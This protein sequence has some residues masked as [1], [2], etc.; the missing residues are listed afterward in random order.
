MKSKLLIALLATIGLSAAAFAAPVTY[1]TDANH[2]FAQFE[3]NHLGFSK[4]TSR[5][6]NVA[7][8]VTLDQ[9]AKKGSADIT[10]DT[11][12][13]DTGSTFFNGH[14]Q[15]EDFLATTQFPTATFQSNDMIF[16][17]EK[18]VALKGVL[19]LKGVSKPVTLKITHFECKKHPMT[20]A[21][22]CGANAEAL[23]KRTEFNMGK[24]A[25]NVGDD[26]TIMIAIE[27][28]HKD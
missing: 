15:G 20:G 14:I 19:T 13:V 11:K 17:G 7:G 27:A 25:P 21:D 2:T 16:K 24:Y 1:T 23:V 18:P 9:A 6:N 28:A 3:Y 5:F 8:T 22:Y 26:V 4:Q 10:I 12:S